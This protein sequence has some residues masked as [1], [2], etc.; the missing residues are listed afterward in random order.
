MVQMHVPVHVAL[1]VVR[2]RY[3]STMLCYVMFHTEMT[4]FELVTLPASKTFCSLHS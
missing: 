4:V 3:K 2:S 1:A